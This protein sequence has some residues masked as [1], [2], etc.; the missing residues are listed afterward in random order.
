MDWQHKCAQRL[1]ISA[2]LVQRSHTL[3]HVW[4]GRDMA[5][6]C[7]RRLLISAILV[8]RSH[9]LGH[10]WFGRDMAYIYIVHSL[11]GHYSLCTLRFK[12]STINSND[13]KYVHVFSFADDVLT[14]MALIS[15]HDRRPCSMHV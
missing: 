3:G 14:C 11:I 9:T 8:Q 2:I 10:V 6:I 12:L 15:N 4:F 1:L 7:A 13:S 5:Y